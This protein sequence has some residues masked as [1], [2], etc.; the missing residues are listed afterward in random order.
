MCVK[1]E[2]ETEKYNLWN[3]YGPNKENEKC[4]FLDQ[5]DKLIDVHGSDGH[6]ILGGDFN[7]DIEKPSNTKS[8]RILKL[9]IKNSEFCDSW[10]KKNPGQKRFTWQ[11]INP[12]CKSVLDYWFIPILLE[13]RILDCQIITAPRT[14]H[15]AVKMKITT[16][17][18]NRGKGTWKFNNSL[19]EDEKYTIELIK[20]IEKSYEEYKDI[21]DKRI[22]WTLLKIRYEASLPIVLI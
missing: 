13:N 6:N 4:A 9:M 1:I 16:G 3:L 11:R 2:I 7:I 19:L 21:I 18:N 20:L 12:P 10:T 5:L 8:H 17:D 22:L 15:L 14:D